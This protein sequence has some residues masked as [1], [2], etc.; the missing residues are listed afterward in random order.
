MKSKKVKENFFKSVLSVK[1]ELSLSS[2]IEII[3]NREA[4]VQGSN[5]VIEYTNESIRIR[6]DDLSV[7]FYGQKLSIEGL[8]QDSLEI[9]GEIQRIEYI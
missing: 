8:T 3:G 2:R 9:K 6:M 4:V 5:G 7:Q 1:D